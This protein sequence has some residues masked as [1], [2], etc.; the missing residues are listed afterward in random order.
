MIWRASSSNARSI[1]APLVLSVAM[2]LF[3]CG[4]SGDP[5][6]SSNS[7]TGRWEI[8]DLDGTEAILELEERDTSIGGRLIVL[9]NREPVGEYALAQ[10]SLSDAGFSF[11]IDPFSPPIVAV[12]D[13]FGNAAPV[14]FDGALVN[15]ETMLLSVSQNCASEQC[16]VA[17]GA[18][19]LETPVFTA[20]GPL[21]RPLGRS[22]MLGELSLI[23]DGASL[24][25][26]IQITYGNAQGGTIGPTLPLVTG[27]VSD[28]STIF[29]IVDPADD[30]TGAL[31]ESLGCAA[32]IRYAG[33][34]D[35]G[36]VVRFFIWQETNV[37]GVIDTC[38]TGGTSWTAARVYDEFEITIPAT[39]AG[40]SY[41]LRIATEQ[42][43]SILDGSVTLEND[44]IRYGPIPIDEGRFSGGVA[45]LTFRPTA[46]GDVELA[47]ELGSGAPVTVVAT[48]A[49]GRTVTLSVLQDCPCLSESV[50]AKRA[51]VGL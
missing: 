24:T 26:N 31:A 45:T 29:F 32:P 16:L 11:T 51:R 15:R 13:A 40:E 22:R 50:L 4:E 18:A 42:E 34:L 17:S 44:D 6:Q 5:L 25:G 43:G 21:D 23:Q 28:T 33:R 20:R 3:G 41:D 35:Q 39:I 36:S 9:E 49:S 46:T 38:F 48:I 1:R 2:L 27:G 8:T 37:A 10:G 47:R 12:I 30:P 14:R 7:I 19:A